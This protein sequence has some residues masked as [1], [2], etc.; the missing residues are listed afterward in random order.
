MEN[1]TETEEIKEATQN[2]NAIRR[3]TKGLEKEIREWGKGNSN[4]N[5]NGHN[6]NPGS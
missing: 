2:L 1:A 5:G 3:M 4:G 6:N